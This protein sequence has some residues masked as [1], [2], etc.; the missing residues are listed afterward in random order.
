M[1]ASIQSPPLPPPSSP[2]VISSFAGF[3]TGFAVGLVTGPAW[4]LKALWTRDG[5]ISSEEHLE[6]V[7]RGD[8][9]STTE[10]T[11]LPVRIVQNIIATPF[12]IVFGGLI[13]S[14]IG[15]GIGIADGVKQ[16]FKI[17]G[18]WIEG[19]VPSGLNGSAAD[20]LFNTEK[21][22]SK[23]QTLVD[24]LEQQTGQIEYS[25][26]KRAMKRLV[27]AN[28]HA[29]A[30]NKSIENA[31]GRKNISINAPDTIKYATLKEGQ[32]YEN[33]RE[34]SLEPKD[35][36]LSMLQVKVASEKEQISALAGKVQSLQSKCK[37]TFFQAL[38]QDIV[39]VIDKIEHSIFADSRVEENVSP[40][41]K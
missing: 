9:Y 33:A 25:D 7:G 5:K 22:V 23:T 16:T 36:D 29:D 13:G 17:P 18:R 35:Y 38:K 6:N 30:V 34:H 14:M 27:K 11:S 41:P 26:Y 39:N 1:G 12:A 40:T 10:P 4:A 3:F 15:G 32:T 21:F 2:S 31:I 20:N 24:T 8:I 28:Y 19:K 37:P